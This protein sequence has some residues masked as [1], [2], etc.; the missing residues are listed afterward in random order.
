QHR[1]LAVDAQFDHAA[2]GRAFDFHGF[3]LLLRVGDLGLHLLGLTHDLR[4]VF[5]RLSESFL[6]GLAVF[7]GAGAGALAGICT[8][9]AGPDGSSFETFMI[10]APGKCF[11][12]S[13]T[14]GWRAISSSSRC[15][16]RLRRSARLSTGAA[17]AFSSGLTRQSSSANSARN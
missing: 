2:A 5:H 12:A 1:V 9:S 7:C 3:Q 4:N 11:S 17:G 14:K 15:A 10:L 13:A 6:P 16:S 8:I